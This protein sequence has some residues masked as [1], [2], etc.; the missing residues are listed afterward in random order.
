M[1]LIL[2]MISSLSCLIRYDDERTPLYL[3]AYNNHPATVKV[4]LEAGCDVNP[5][6]IYKVN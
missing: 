1:S 5:V 3:A 4:L 2:N 6:D